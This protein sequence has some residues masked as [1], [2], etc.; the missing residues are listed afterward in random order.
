MN[1][2]LK[3]FELGTELECTQVPKWGG[4]EAMFDYLKILLLPPSGLY[5]G[6]T[7]AHGLSPKSAP[8]RSPTCSLGHN[9][10]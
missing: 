1:F 2:L 7:N 9:R 3:T 10:K 6:V 8:G 5:W 4:G